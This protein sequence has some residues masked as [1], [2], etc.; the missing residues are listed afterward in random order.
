MRVH[1]G[2]PG[3]QDLCL[4][5]LQNGASTAALL[6]IVRGIDLVLKT[7]DE[8]RSWLVLPSVVGQGHRHDAHAVSLHEDAFC[9]VRSA[10][11]CDNGFGR[12]VD[13]LVREVV[14]GPDPGHLF[15]KGR[16]SRHRPDEM[17][18]QS[19]PLHNVVLQVVLPYN[20]KLDVALQV[21]AS[22]AHGALHL[23]KAVTSVAPSAATAM[24]P[25]AGAVSLLIVVVVMVVA[26]M[27][28][29]VVVGR[30]KHTLTA[31]PVA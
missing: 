19:R 26:I 3:P 17:V 13:L 5:G 28:V 16:L 11:F 6:W 15:L 10:L 31:C 30:F 27:V 18:R 1:C 22:V 21:A 25:R 12:S 24:A 14:D 8:E 20:T 23:S 7:I 4:L 29:I 2:R 9:R